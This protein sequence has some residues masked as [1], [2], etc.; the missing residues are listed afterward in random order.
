MPEAEEGGDEPKRDVRVLV[1]DRPA[2]G[3]SKVVVLHL[4]RPEPSLDLGS[5]EVRLR[6]LRQSQEPPRVACLDRR[7]M[8]LGVEPL[9]AELAD[10]PVHVEARFGRNRAVR[11]DEAAVDEGGDLIQ[12]VGAVL[13]LREAHGL[14]RLERRPAHHDREPPKEEALRMRQEVIAPFD[15]RLQRPLAIGEIPRALVEDRQVALHPREHRGGAEET[16]PGCRELDGEGQA[17]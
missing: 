14:G 13:I 1:L 3:R 9:E 12:D 2:E 4:E 11:M 5:A 17:V 10:R 8:V 7:T 15:G 16:G 6:R